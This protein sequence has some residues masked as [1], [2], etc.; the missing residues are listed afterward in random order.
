MS[1]PSRSRTEDRQP[2]PEEATRNVDPRSEP[3]FPEG[4]GREEFLRDLRRVTRRRPDEDQH[5]SS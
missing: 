1:P 5:P 4:W 3:V 2:T